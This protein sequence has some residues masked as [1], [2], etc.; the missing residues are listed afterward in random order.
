MKVCRQIVLVGVVGG[1]L[2]ALAPPPGASPPDPL[3]TVLQSE[4]ARNLE[5]LKKESAPPY[6]VSYAVSDRRSTR[7]QASFGA[8]I[9]STDT[10]RRRL[11]TDLR[12]GGYDLDSTH[13]VRGGDRLSA[14]LMPRLSVTSLPLTDDDLAIRSVVWRVTDRSYRQAVEGLTR[15]KTNIATKVKEEATVADFSRETPQVSIGQPAS[16]TID[17]KEWEQ[18]LRRLTAPFAEAPQTYI[19]EAS[20]SVDADTHYFVSSEGTQ[21]LHGTTTA[22][23]VVRSLTK[24]SD[25]MELPLFITY[26]APLP[27]G[28]PRED[29]M[30]AEVRALIKQAAALR[31]A[32]LIEPYS[33]PAVLSGRAAAVFFHEIFGHRIEGARQK[34]VDDA[35]TF[36]KKVGQPILP[37]FISVVSDP[38][39]RKFGDVDLSGY[40]PYDDEGV[41]GQRVVVVDKGVLRTFLMSRS[42]V[43]GFPQSNGHGRA[44][45]GSTPV[46][47]QSNL[48][49]ESTQAVPYAQLLEQLKSEVKRQ[50]K[51]FGL[52]FDNIEG[53]V[54]M[55]GRTMPNAFTVMPTV[56]YRVYADNRPP[57]L[58]RG[59]DIIGTPLAAFAKILATGD[60]PEIFNGVCG[61][62]SGPVPVSAISP[63]LL[64]SELEVQKK[65]QSQEMVPILPPPDKK[66]SS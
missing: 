51:P 22:R 7:I 6:F 24:A 14:M 30:V 5:V 43:A 39:L 63:P 2:C 25:G 50:G 42:P 65:T 16:Y 41:K 46:S 49:I 10:R 11:T 15:V 31:S 45:F 18:R 47:R 1:V 40:Y 17:T 62:E 57:E 13:Q 61:A 37:P 66:K 28:L 60:K 8:L 44:D 26:E 53:G 19:G 48:V 64:V 55:T 36:S 56:V 27:A 33:G 34:S 52:L 12:V 54:T 20:L 58:V 59:V 4:M 38:T 3:L 21:L 29:R 9:G 35:Q 32:P 23:I